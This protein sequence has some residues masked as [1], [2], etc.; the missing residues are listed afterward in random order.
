MRTPTRTGRCAHVRGRLPSQ[1]TRTLTLGCVR[2]HARARHPNTQAQRH[3]GGPF[4]PHPCAHCW[5]ST[6]PKHPQQTPTDTYNSKNVC[7]RTYTRTCIICAK[8]AHTV[9]NSNNPMQTRKNLTL[10]ARARAPPQP[11]LNTCTTIHA[12]YLLFVCTHPRTGASKQMC[13]HTRTCMYTNTRTRAYSE[14]T[15]P[16]THTR[17]GTR[18]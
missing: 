17:T 11:T 18:T 2:R 5:F 6:R 4:E 8:S 12:D 16:H 1:H 9:Q 7:A 14:H 15:Y 3:R 13:A 10:H